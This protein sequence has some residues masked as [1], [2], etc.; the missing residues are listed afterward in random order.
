MDQ[1]DFDKIADNTAIPDSSFVFDRVSRRRSRRR[2]VK[3]LAL[4]AVL[5][6]VSI[7]LSQMNWDDSTSITTADAEAVPTGADDQQGPEEEETVPQELLSLLDYEHWV[8]AEANGLRGGLLPGS[9]LMTFNT[10]MVKGEPIAQI[11][12][13]ASTKVV[14]LEEA[15]NGF[16][17][18]D[19]D[20]PESPTPWSRGPAPDEATNGVNGLME[21]GSRIR[22]LPNTTNGSLHIEVSYPDDERVS[23][24]LLPWNSEFPTLESVIAHGVA[25]WTVTQSSGELLGAAFIWDSFGDGTV[26]GLRYECG[27]VLFRAHWEGN[28]VQIGHRID[29]E[30]SVPAACEAELQTGDVVLFSTEPVLGQPLPQISLSV[31]SDGW[32]A[33]LEAG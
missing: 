25:R 33:T 8:V 19:F 31:E 26:I 9:V 14:R 32:R 30:N 29:G 2:G 11:A 21:E 6:F 15:P 22:V 18:Q 28:F 24:R 5:G 17:V 7:F 20:G 1:I 12:Y 23:M 10:G 3:M 16:V 13:F 4:V 27:T